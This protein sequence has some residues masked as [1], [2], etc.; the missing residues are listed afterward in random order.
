LLG[1]R[2]PRRPHFFPPA[3]NAGRREIGRVVI[4]PHIHPA[5]VVRD[6]VDSVWNRL[7]Q[8]LIEEI[9]DADFFR[10]ALR[11][12]FLAWIPEVAHQFLLFRVHRDHRLATLL[13]AHGLSVDVLKLS[14]AVRMLIAFPRLAVGLQAVARFVQQP[15]HRAITDAMTPTT[16]LVRQLTS[17]LTGP[18]Q[19]RFRIAARQRFHQRFQGG[20][21]RRIRCYQLFSSATRLPQP[22]RGRLFRM[23]SSILQ[24]AQ[25][26]LNGVTG[27]SRGVRHSGHASIAKLPRFGRG[28]L[29]TRPLIQYKFQR[30]ELA[31]NPFNCS[32][33]L[34]PK[35]IARSAAK[36]NPKLT[37]LFLPAP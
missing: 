21:Q 8:L 18:T 11:V 10:L 7:A 37:T 31:T 25:P 34:H 1:T 23:L 16:Q 27:E 33:I 3:P 32:C 4:D 9:V 12:P 19:R 22:F 17:T 36:E 30:L 35:S 26:Q 29:A 15:R 5:L 13:K 24:L 2:K 14:I 6:I 28:P 20:H